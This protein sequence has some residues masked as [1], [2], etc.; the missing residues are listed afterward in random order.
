VDAPTKTSPC[1]ASRKESDTVVRY[2]KK[3][4]CGEV[5][6]GDNP[7]PGEKSAEREEGSLRGQFP[8]C[9]FDRRERSKDMEEGKRRPSN[10]KG[11]RR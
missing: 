10:R 4:F 1:P 7:E 5:A 9:G 11:K 8:E 6:R 2:Y 3:R